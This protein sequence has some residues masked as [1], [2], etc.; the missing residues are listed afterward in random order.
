MPVPS[1]YVLEHGPEKW[2]F[3]QQGIRC[4]HCGKDCAIPE[5]HDHVDEHQALVVR[6]LTSRVRGELKLV[7]EMCDQEVKV[8]GDGANS[9]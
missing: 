3:D 5:P 9:D 2:Y 7:Y 4:A 8:E 1:H 6:S